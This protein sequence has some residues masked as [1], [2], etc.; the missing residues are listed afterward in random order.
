MKK[1]IILFLMFSAIVFAEWKYGI[2]HNEHGVN[3]H[4]FAVYDSETY[5]LLIVSVSLDVGNGFSVVEIYNDDVKKNDNLKLYIKD[6]SDDTMNYSIFKN[7]IEDGR[8]AIQNLDRYNRG[9]TL[10]KILVSAQSVELYDGDTYDTLSTFN[11][12][13]LE[14]I[15]EKKLGNSDWYKYKLFGNWK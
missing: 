5:S 3:F 13:G 11:L 4:E 1:I 15:L 8:I 14:Q 7:D 12:K 10:T 6:N 2:T 9:D